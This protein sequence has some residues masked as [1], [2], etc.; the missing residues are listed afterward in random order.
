MQ[1][2]MKQNPLPAEEITELLETNP[3]GTISTLLEDGTPYAVPAHFALYE[4]NIYLHGLSKGQKIDNILKDPRV[5]F[6][7]FEM[8]EKL[9]ADVEMACKVNT[10]YRSVIIIGK[11]SIIDDYEKKETALNAIIKKYT[12]QFADK[13][14]PENMVNGT[15]VIEIVP[16][17]TTGKYY[18]DK[19]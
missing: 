16:I 14:L 17:E 3:V 19:T 8:A 4:G 10:E 5:C 12:P 15:A 7:T 13:K 6:E 9:L 11:A 1:N 2:R 18:K